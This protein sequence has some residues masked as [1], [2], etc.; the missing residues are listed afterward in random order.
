MEEKIRRKRRLLNNICEMAQEVSM[1]FCEER[2]E[3]ILHHISIMSTALM[4]L[5]GIEG[6]ER[7]RKSLGGISPKAFQEQCRMVL[8]ELRGKGGKLDEDEERFWLGQWYEESHE[9]GWALLFL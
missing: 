5:E 1:D 6:D 4:M 7:P 3:R 9:Q 8:C 2:K